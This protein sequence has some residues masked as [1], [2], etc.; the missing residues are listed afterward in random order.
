MKTK[1]CT[2]CLNDKLLIEFPPDKHYKGG[3]ATWCRDCKRPLI[4]VAKKRWL[5][6]HPDY[7][8]AYIRQ[9]MKK[10]RTMQS[11]IPKINAHNILNHAID[12]GEIVRK[13]CYKCGSVK[14]IEGHHFDYSYPLKVQWLCPEHHRQLHAMSLQ[15][16]ETI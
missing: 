16:Q 7:E 4:K 8:R 14:N 11:E 1:T 15:C 3:Y 10:R 9:Y 12:R 6:R 13:P 2:K 5:K